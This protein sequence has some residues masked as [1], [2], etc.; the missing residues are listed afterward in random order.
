MRTPDTQL[1][2][3]ALFVELTDGPS[4]P[5][6]AFVLNSGDI[7]LL[8][9]LDLLSHMDAS[10]SV[11]G[12]ATVAAHVEH[13]RYGLSLL[14]RWAVEG[15]DAYANPLWDVAWQTSAVSAAQW[16]ESRLGLREEIRNWRATLESPRELNEVELKGLIASVAHFA[17]HLGAI[18][19]IAPGSRGPK[20]GTFTPASAPR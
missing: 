10:H 15:A 11:N 5:G 17:Y 8:S 14:N 12:G 4:R 7:G 3:A 19:Q 16:E 2:L 6:G 13:L 1:A 9:S 20:E 18:R